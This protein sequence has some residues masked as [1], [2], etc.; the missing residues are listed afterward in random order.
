MYTILTALVRYVSIREMTRVPPALSP[1]PAGDPAR[2][3][4][5]AGEDPLAELL[6]T[7]VQAV[8]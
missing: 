6:P 3:P 2:A 5:S 1:Q 8:V 4:L 7:P